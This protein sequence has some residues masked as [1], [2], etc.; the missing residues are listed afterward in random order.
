M[1]LLIMEYLVHALMDI[2]HE[3]GTTVYFVES[4]LCGSIAGVVA[5]TAIAPAERVKMS[6][7]IS[8]DKFTLRSAFQRGKEMALKDGILSLW[9][10]HSTT[11]LRV[12]PFSGISYAAHDM[13]EQKFKKY[14]KTDNLPFMYKFLA[15]SIGGATGTFYTYPLDVL[16][17]RLALT[18]GSTWLTTVRQGGLFQGLTPTIMG[19]IPYSGKLREGI[20]TSLRYVCV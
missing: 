4:I 16:R 14:L 11:V 10:G 1:Y 17:V 6:F 5:K 13:A 9:K 19:I 18:P 15:G 2:S 12:A 8:L 20:F 7:Q 3:L